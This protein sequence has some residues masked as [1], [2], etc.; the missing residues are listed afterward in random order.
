LKHC[1]AD[2]KVK[3]KT[4]DVSSKVKKKKPNPSVIWSECSCSGVGFPGPEVQDIFLYLVPW[5]GWV[6][7]Q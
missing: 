1:Q 2:G 4:P 6:H 3:G 5:G 7:R